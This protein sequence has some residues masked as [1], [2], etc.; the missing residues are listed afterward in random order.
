MV[1]LS[2][3]CVCCTFDD[4]SDFDHHNDSDTD[5][6]TKSSIVTS[7]QASLFKLLRQGPFD[8]IIIET[9]GVR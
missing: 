4:T 7:I 9:S 8:H 5:S 3:G 2:S 1:S 6:D